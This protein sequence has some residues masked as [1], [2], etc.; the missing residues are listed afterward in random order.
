MDQQHKLIT[1]NAKII[2]FA[3]TPIYNLTFAAKDQKIIL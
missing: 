3:P 1:K 2:D